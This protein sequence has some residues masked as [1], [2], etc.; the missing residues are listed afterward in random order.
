MAEFLRTLENTGRL[1]HGA[2]HRPS[3][4]DTH[5]A[6]PNRVASATMRGESMRW[7]PRPGIAADRGEFLKRLDGLLVGP[8]PAEGVFRGDRFLHPDLDLSLR[9]P[10]GWTTANSRAAVEAVSP[11]RDA[12]VTL[13]HQGRGEDPRR[14][15]RAFLER[16]AREAS[17][18]L[19][20]SEPLTI[21]GL[22]AFRAHAAAGTEQGTRSLEL[23]WIAYG[24][25]IYRV[26]GVAPGGPFRRYQG[27]FR[28]VARSFRPLDEAE[29]ASIRTTRMRVMAAREGETLSEVGARTGNAW[30]INET[31]VANAL[32]VDSVLEPGQLVKVAIEEPYRPRGSRVS[33]LAQ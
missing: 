17:L 21:S 31:A 10:E 30:N 33:P 9:F 23:T 11:R 8:N 2:S 13:Q 15:A 25:L 1:R 18:R 3:F 32:F 27:L 4:F 12:S 5:P 16:L 28:N 14:A 7:R 22:S 20:R 29:R 19:I 24:G 6:T 26:A